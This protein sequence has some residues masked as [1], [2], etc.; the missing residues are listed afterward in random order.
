[1]VFD[2]G[3]NNGD[4]TAYYLHK[5]YDVLAVEANPQLVEKVKPRFAAEIKSGRLTILNVGITEVEGNIPFWICEAVSEWSSFNRA[6]ASRDNQ[7]HHEIVVPGRRFEAIIAEYGVP[8][9]LKV[10]IEGNDQI[11][12]DGLKPGTLPEYVSVEAS[13][14]DQVD[15]L[16]RLG[17]TRFKCISQFHYLPLELPPIPEQK[18]YEQAE[19]E[20]QSK[21]LLTPILRRVGALK[22][23]E[24][25][26]NQTRRDG[27]WVF[28]FGSSGPFGECQL[29]RWQTHREIM[30]TF[31]TFQRMMRSGESSPFWK[32]KDYSFWADFHAAK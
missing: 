1:M 29:G 28:P 20:L 26:K 2:I 32:D 7:P 16:A 30:E 6:I 17:Y 15:F 14:L 18:S 8:F 22:S 11:C 4:D 27:E 10:D 13:S 9:Y 5:G 3:M 31:A 25:L 23:I 21:S 19:R 24:R 12:L